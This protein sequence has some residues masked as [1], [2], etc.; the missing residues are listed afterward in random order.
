MPKLLSAITGAVAT[1]VMTM[2][3]AAGEPPTVESQCVNRAG[4]VTITYSAVWPNSCRPRN[5]RVEVNGRVVELHA[6]STSGFCLAVLTPY[7]ITGMRN[8]LCDGTYQTVV[9]LS[10]SQG[11]EVQRIAGAEVVFVCS[12]ADFNDD[13]SVSVQDIFDFSNGLFHQRPAGGCQRV[14][15]GDGAGCLRLSDRVLPGTVMVRSQSRSSLAAR[16]SSI[17]TPSGR[18]SRNSLP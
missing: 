12:I 5:P 9:V 4:E 11:M 15:V 6:Q 17:R 2:A 3:A 13:C 18:A 16:S 7:T 8:G 1:G 14:A 10:N